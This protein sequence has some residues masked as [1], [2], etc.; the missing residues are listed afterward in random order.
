MSSGDSMEE[1]SSGIII[2]AELFASFKDFETSWDAITY[3]DEPTLVDMKAQIT[4]LNDD[5]YA[6]Y[7]YETSCT[8][9]HHILV[10]HF[11]L[12]EKEF[13]TFLC[14]YM[15]QGDIPDTFKNAYR[16]QLMITDERRFVSLMLRAQKVRD[17]FFGADCPPGV[18][19]I[20]VSRDGKVVVSTDEEN[21]IRVNH[22]FKPWLNIFVPIHYWNDHI[23]NE[24]SNRGSE[25]VHDVY[26]RLGALLEQRLSDQ[27]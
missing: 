9:F 18:E 5:D 16:F 6:L 8:N 11:H 2:D 12:S 20:V 26:A 4:C 24:L 27:F 19:R 13:E 25:S 21:S 14:G 22:I 1:A 23:F 10:D 3:A 7:K 17:A 15:K